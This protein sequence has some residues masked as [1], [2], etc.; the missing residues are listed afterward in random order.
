MKVRKRLFICFMILICVLMF[1]FSSCGNEKNRKDY[2]DIPKG[3][4]AIEETAL[5]I[6]V[7][8][9]AA[10]ISYDGGIAKYD[11]ITQNRSEIICGGRYTAVY[12]SDE[13]LVAFESSEGKVKEFSP[14]GELISS[15]DVALKTEQVY[16]ITAD[17]RYVAFAVR[18]ESEINKT[19]TELYIYH[20]DKGELKNISEKF[21][22]NDGFSYIH[23]IVFTYDGKLA[24]CSSYEDSL[25]SY[26]SKLYL[27][28]V[29][30]ER[31]EEKKLPDAEKYFYDIDENS[32]YCAFGQVLSKVDAEGNQ[33]KLYEFNDSDYREYLS[34]Y[35]TTYIPERIIHYGNNIFL[36]ES[37]SKF[38]AVLNTE[39]ANGEIVIL[40][41]ENVWEINLDKVVRRFTEEYDCAVNILTY[42]E[43]TYND[44]LRQKLLAGE[45]D[46]DIFFVG[47]TGE[48]MLLNAILQNGLFEDLSAYEEVSENLDRGIKNLMSKEGKMF[49]I[50][51]AVSFAGTLLEVNADPEGYEYTMPK[52]NWTTEDLWTLCEEMIQKGNNE[53]TVFNDASTVNRII[54]SYIQNC[55]G[56]GE[57]DRE[58]LEKLLGNIKK[59]YDAGVLYPEYGKV[60]NSLFKSSI[61]MVNLSEGSLGR[62]YPEN[63]TVLF[64]SVSGKV[65]VYLN[66]CV[67]MN[68]ESDSKEMAA[69][70]FKILTDEESVYDT[71]NGYAY[72]AGEAEG[73]IHDEGTYKNAVIGGD[74]QKY[75]D[76]L[77]VW[78]S[79]DKAY[80]EKMIDVYENSLPLT[81]DTGLIDISEI[82]EKFFAGTI[83]VKEA[84]DIISGAVE[85]SCFE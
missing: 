31:S 11:L 17:E 79:D 64:P 8:D 60:G 76:L 65:S 39:H 75:S 47:K 40:M 69:G 38:I 33:T 71:G 1:L 15:Y 44:K 10:Y 22:G 48:D 13:I 7:W 4:T 20:K 51:Y 9:T 55:I 23:D 19:A 45:S 57:Y 53:L 81:F 26:A 56:R 84:C 6:S 41:P 72:A 43:D 70:F 27:Y 32:V 12:A 24:V 78:N 25:Y 30:K 42:P 66:G 3:E 62:A 36:L 58:G 49:G 54:Y 50:P 74:V 18:S 83:S 16:R 67:I 85:Y 29:K 28:D 14:N 68:K 21:R 63:G 59:Y 5:D 46:Y 80:F 61:D 52:S 82:R 34:E 73:G 2:T 35:I 37:Y 77:R